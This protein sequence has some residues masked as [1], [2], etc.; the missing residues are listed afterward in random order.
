M[1]GA[2]L[3]KNEKKVHVL[4]NLSPHM[5]FANF[6]PMFKEDITLWEYLSKQILTDFP[7]SIGKQCVTVYLRFR[8]TELLHQK[9]LPLL[10]I[11]T[12][13]IICDCLI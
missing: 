7:V 1:W 3:P 10:H 11:I 4:L 8:S 9:Y 6:F 2:I 13:K 5:G 12:L